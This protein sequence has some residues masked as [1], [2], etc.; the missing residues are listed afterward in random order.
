MIN[1]VFNRLDTHQ[2][3]GTHSANLDM[4]QIE[5]R[6]SNSTLDKTLQK[7]NEEAKD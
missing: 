7:K 2:R 4:K 5:S 6:V 3:F 1:A